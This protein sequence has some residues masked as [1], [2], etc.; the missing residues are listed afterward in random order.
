MTDT[1]PDS[2]TIALMLALAAL[3]AAALSTRRR[4]SIHSGSHAAR[5]RRLLHERRSRP[6]SARSA[7][8]RQQ[9]AAR[10]TSWTAASSHARPTTTSSSSRTR[11]ADP[12]ELTEPLTQQSAGTGKAEEF[13]KITTNNRLRKTL[14]GALASFDLGDPSAIGASRLRARSCC[15]PS[16]KT[17]SRCCAS[18]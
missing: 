6:Q 13:S 16:T 11:D 10:R 8:R 1:W 9:A 15:E 14:R 12:L 17:P 5:I 3:L 4:R 18:R 2:L 7:P